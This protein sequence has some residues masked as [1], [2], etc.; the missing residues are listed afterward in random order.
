[1]YCTYCKEVVSLTA[2]LECPICL[3]TSF[4][5]KPKKKSKTAKEKVEKSEES[6]PEE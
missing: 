2:E 1:M 5:E 6:T 4:G 3:G